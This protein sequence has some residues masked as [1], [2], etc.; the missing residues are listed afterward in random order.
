MRL[1]YSERRAALAKSI[2]GE[3]GD[4]VKILGA[5]AGMHMTVTLPEGLHDVEIASRAA[6]NRVWLWPLSPS[7][8]STKKRQGFVLGFGSAPTEQIPQAVRHVRAAFT[9]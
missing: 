5:E 2:H 3:F 1:L 6:R 8:L 9:G 4:E 7:Y